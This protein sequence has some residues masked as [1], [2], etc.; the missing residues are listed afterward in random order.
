M[1]L[2]SGLVL[3]EKS[4]TVHQNEFESPDAAFREY[5]NDEIEIMN[6]ELTPS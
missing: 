6:D 4:N 1:E 5:S 2:D 3:L